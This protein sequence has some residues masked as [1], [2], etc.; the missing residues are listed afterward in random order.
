V[1][2]DMS[3]EAEESP[4]LRSITRKRLVKADCEDLAYDLVICKVW[5]SAMV[6]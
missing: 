1:G 2:N 3:A 5:E 4:S 6:L